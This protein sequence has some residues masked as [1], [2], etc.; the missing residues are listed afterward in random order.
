M[1]ALPLDLYDSALS[2]HSGLRPASLDDWHLRYADGRR[3]PLALRRWCSTADAVDL[4]ILD[5]C[6]DPSLDVGCGPGRLVAAL[7]CAGREALGVDIAGAAIQLTHRAGADAVQ[8]SVFDPLPNEGAWGTVLLIDGNIGIGGDPVALLRRCRDLA[9][10][11]GSLLIELDAPGET[12]SNV[13]VRLESQRQ[14]SR[15]FDWAHVAADE[16]VAPA[17]DAGLRVVDSWAM[18]GRWFASLAR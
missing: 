7:A 1:T 5:R 2:T 12:S 4:E 16:I 15:W 17:A 13:Q 18:E 10:V 8:R 11:D 6:T 9:A 3:I 14:R